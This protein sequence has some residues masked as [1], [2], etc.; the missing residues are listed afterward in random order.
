MGLP[1]NKFS[2]RNLLLPPVR[3][4]GAMTG[5]LFFCLYI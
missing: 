1:R 3:R 5:F 2:F 4:A